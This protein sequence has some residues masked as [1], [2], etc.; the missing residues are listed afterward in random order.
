MGRPNFTLGLGLGSCRVG[1]TDCNGGSSPVITTLGWL[2][3]TCAHRVGSIML[4][5]QDAGPTLPLM[6]IRDS[7]S[8][9]MTTK[10]ALSPCPGLDGWGDAI[11]PST[12]TT[13]RQMRN[14]AALPCSQLWIWLTQT[15]TNRVEPIMQY[16]G[17]DEL[18]VRK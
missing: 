9:L 4:P 5:W 17:K 1:Q 3:Y 14:G 11:F 10:P 15:C 18:N 13:T 7:S 16:K 12:H 2:T 6:G 8:T